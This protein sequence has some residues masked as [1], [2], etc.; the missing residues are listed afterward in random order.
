MQ[1][2]DNKYEQ[3]YFIV[4][5]RVCDGY[6]YQHYQWSEEKNFYK[7]KEEN[8]VIEDGQLKGF[9]YRDVFFALDELDVWKRIDDADVCLHLSNKNCS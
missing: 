2:T 4:K 7:V 8:A 3:Y 1:M 6:I 9:C 5:Q